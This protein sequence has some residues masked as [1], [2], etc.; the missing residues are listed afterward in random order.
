[1]SRGLSAVAAIVVPLL[2][3]AVLALVWVGRDVAEPE[4]GVPAGPVGTA[5]AELPVAPAG[6]MT[7]YSRSAF[8]PA[9]ADVDDNGCSTREDVLARD[10]TGIVV[11]DDGCRVLS[12]T[13][14]DPYG[15]GTVDFVRGVDTSAAV[16][17]D[18]V[19]ALA[20]AWRTGARDWDAERRERF[21]NDPLELL[22]V[23]GAENQAKGDDDAAEWLPVEG[24]CAYAARQVAV[25]SEWGLWVTP[26]ERDALAAVL[27]GC[28]GQEL[29][30][31]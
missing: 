19:V 3:L 21:A 24:A 20:A 23:A 22:A 10:L 6:T 7:G 17:I 15:A 16:Q 28:P 29:P 27:T 13:L 11:A 9:W 14:A 18:H 5:L 25:K 2:V 26:D 4:V 30:R 31:R 12:G 8:G 1:M